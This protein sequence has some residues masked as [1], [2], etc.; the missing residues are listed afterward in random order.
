M[1]D[2]IELGREFFE[3]LTAVDAAITARVA[4]GACSRC[5]GPLHVGNYPRKPRGGLFAMEGESLTLRFSVVALAVAT[6]ASAHRSTGT[7][8][9]TLRRWV[10]WW[11]GAFPETAVFAALSA[12]LGVAGTLATGA[13]SFAASTLA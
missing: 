5:G 11:R 7:A 3:K 1:F 2:P 6:A 8:A 4:A 10:G 9:R 13:R 12:R